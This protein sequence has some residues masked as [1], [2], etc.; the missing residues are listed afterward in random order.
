MG[1]KTDKSYFFNNDKLSP[2]ASIDSS[3]M[4]L[5]STKKYSYMSNLS[6]RIR[7]AA[8]TLTEIIPIAEQIGVTRISDI[9][10]LD[11]LYIPNFSVVLPGTEDSIWV[12]SGKGPTKL[13]AKVGALMEAIERYSSLSQIYSKGFIQGSYLQISKSFNKLLHPAEV[14]EPVNEDF[15]YND[16]VVDFVPGYDLQNNETV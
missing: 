6:T 5:K 3:P 14:V 1:S 12:Y 2:K 10:Y 8:D 9:T 13:N 16:S 15:S 7:S 11:K 4:R